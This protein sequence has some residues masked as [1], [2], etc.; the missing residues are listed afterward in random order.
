MAKKAKIERERKTQVAPSKLPHPTKKKKK[1][2]EKKETTR[3]NEHQTKGSIKKG[4][5]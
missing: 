2:D 4:L 3:K 5:N 1:A